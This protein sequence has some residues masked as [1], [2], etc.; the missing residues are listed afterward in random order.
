MNKEQQVI[1]LILDYGM[2]DGG[3]HKQ[4]V[5]TEI[6]KILMGDAYDAWLED[7]NS[8]EEYSDWDEGIAP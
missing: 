6:L 4:W 3:H 1:D 5:L 8:D 2:T 7:Y